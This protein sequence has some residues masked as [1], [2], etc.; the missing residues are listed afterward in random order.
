MKTHKQ[1]FVKINAPVDAAIC[2]LVSALG[3]FPSLETI[4]SCQGSEK[5]S[6]WV[7]FRYGNYWDHPWRDLAAFVFG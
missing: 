7:C 2:D 5:S 1:V 4:E 6:A 3:A